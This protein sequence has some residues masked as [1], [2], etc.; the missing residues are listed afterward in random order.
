MTGRRGLLAVLLVL[1]MVTVSFAPI[2]TTVAAEIDSDGDGFSDKYERQMG[3]DPEDPDDY[4]G[5]D[6]PIT[7]PPKPEVD[8]YEIDV[9]PSRR[10]TPDR[11][12]ISAAI[13][14][15]KD[16]ALVDGEAVH[17]KAYIKIGTVLKV[18]DQQESVL[19]DGRA[20]FQFK[21]YDVGI[22]YLV[23]CMDPKEAGISGS[24]TPGS[25]QRLSTQGQCGY[26]IIAVYQ[27]HFATIE[28][29]FPHLIPGMKARM[30]VRFYELYT[31]GLSEAIIDKHMDRVDPMAAMELYKRIPGKTYVDVDGPAGFS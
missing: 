31:E 28:A 8:R 16:G 6:P 19:V 5:K 15:R 1:V 29:D 20:S 24:M 17:F 10:I 21:P 11:E 7:P 18:V 22:Y 27:K 23:S 12:T 13:Y 25:F 26:A 30:T 2:A 9:L 4:P 14:V 3:T